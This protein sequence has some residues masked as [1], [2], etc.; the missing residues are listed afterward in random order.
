VN[1]CDLKARPDRIVGKNLAP[2]VS[3]SVLP[4]V[5]NLI[6]DAVLRESVWVMSLLP[7]VADCCCA[8]RML[9]R[10]SG[11][12]NHRP[13][14]GNII[15]IIIIIAI[16]RDAVSLYLEERFQSNLAQVFIV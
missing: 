12:L 10:L 1:A 16:S 9:V 5:L 11:C 15:I 4:S 13:I 14:K 2:L 8:Y 7:C 3:D 6:V